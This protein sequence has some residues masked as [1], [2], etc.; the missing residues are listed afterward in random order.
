MKKIL[1]VLAATLLWTTADAQDHALFQKFRFIQNGDTLPYRLLLPEHYDPQKKYPLVL[2]LHGRGESGSDNEAQLLHGAAIFLK[3]ENRK[4]FPAIVVFPQNAAKYYWSNVQT[5]ADSSGKRSF[6]FIAGGEPSPSMQLV[7][8]LMRNL[9]RQYKIKKDQVYVMG[10]SMGGMGTFEIVN[11]MPHTFAA[12]IPICGGAD[13]GIAGNLKNTAW[14][15]FHGG[16]DEV[17]SPEYSRK[18][19]RAMKANGV[20]VQFTVYPG[21]GHNSWDAAFAE[22]GLLGW[23]FAHK[24]KNNFS[25]TSNN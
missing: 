23:L 15:V 6:Y 9:D 11:R 2:F 7:M 20:P 21:A 24:R 14:W 12:A 16:K 10:L 13:P 8:A 4:Q 19:V 3:E 25:K 18:M 17:V 5:V 22:P 1:F